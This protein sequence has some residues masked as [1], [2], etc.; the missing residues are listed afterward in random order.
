MNIYDNYLG[1]D[2]SKKKLD[3]VNDKGN[4][5]QFSND[6]SGFK[7]LLKIVPKSSL[8]I[9][10]VTGIYHLNLALFLHSKS[11]A[12]SVVNP[13]QIKRFIQMQLKRIKTDK[14]DAKMICLYGKTQQPCLWEPKECTLSE[15][16]DVYQ[17]MEQLID[18]RASLKNKL[19]E[20]KTKKAMDYIILSVKNQ[21]LSMTTTIEELEKKVISLIKVNHT[22]LLSNIKTIPGIGD[23]TAPLLIIASNGFTNFDNAKQLASYFGIAP[24]Q[25][26]SGSSVRG[27]NS[28]S[29]MG[30]PLVRKKLYMCSLQASKRNTSC[31]LLYQRLLQKGKPKKLALIAVANKLLNIVFAL[32]KSGIPYDPHYVSTRKTM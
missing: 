13:L 22:E 14:A 21:I 20:L 7:Q 26:E 4:H 1:I 2:V 9:M 27:S 11:I 29:K 12:L 31:A 30:N 15:S 18:I 23:R 32:Y 8:C 28:I 19:E 24:T 25:T 16:Q 3:V 5:Y 6:E 17:T 10:E